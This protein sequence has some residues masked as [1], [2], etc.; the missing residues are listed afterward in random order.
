MQSTKLTKHSAELQTKCSCWCK[1]GLHHTG[2]SGRTLP[3]SNWSFVKLAS[4]VQKMRK[5][6]YF[7]CNLARHLGL[8]QQ[9]N[10]NGVHPIF[11]NVVSNGSISAVKSKKSQ[12]AK[13]PCD[14][15]FVLSHQNSQ[16]YMSLVANPQ[17]KQKRKNTQRRCFCL[18]S[19]VM[20]M[21]LQVQ[22]RKH[23]TCM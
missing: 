15:V 8:G 20:L 6:I 19:L 23:Q 5:S 11:R 18:C 13:I 16:Q 9:C 4:L 12:P 7:N 22:T 1:V 10:V 3:S 17:I 2:L 14:W 21:A